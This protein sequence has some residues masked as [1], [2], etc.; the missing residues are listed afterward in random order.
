MTFIVSIRVGNSVV[1]GFGT[2]PS[3]GDSL[4]RKLAPGWPQV[5]T[6]RLDEANERKVSDQVVVDLDGDQIFSLRFEENRGWGS[7]GGVEALDPV[8]RHRLIAHWLRVSQREMPWQPIESFTIVWTNKAAYE[9]QLGKIIESE[10]HKLNSS[11]ESL[12]NRGFPKGRRSSD[13]SSCCSNRMQHNTMP[14][15]MICNLLIPIADYP[16]CKNEH[17]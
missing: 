2:G 1:S 12:R 8:T 7:C 13:A 10:R 17:P 5:Y 15:R 11:V 9:G 4:G 14:A 3:C 6:Y 16:D